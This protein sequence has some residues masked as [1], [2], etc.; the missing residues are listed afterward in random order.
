MPVLFWLDSGYRWSQA[1]GMFESNRCAAVVPCFNEA[2]SIVSLIEALK[3]YV[4]SITVVDDGSRDNTADSAAKAGATVV[5][6]ERNMGKGAALRTG[7]ARVRKMGFEWAVTLDGDGQ[8]APEDLPVLFDCARTNGAPLVVGNRMAAAERMCWLRRQVNRFMSWQ[9]SRRAGRQLPDT[10]CGLRLIHLPTW[11]RLV[12]KTERFEIES[13]MLIAFLAAGERVEFVPVQV[14]PSNRK[15]RIRP[16]AD[17]VRWLRWWSAS[18]RT[19]KQVLRGLKI[20]E[21]A[22]HGEMLAL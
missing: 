10:Q 1:V 22:P 5:R 17:T 18:A 2:A 8:H 4:P 11:E 6:H 16:L 14:I 3:G 9:L 13:E 20:K 21:P 7:L 19:S 12:L 15:S